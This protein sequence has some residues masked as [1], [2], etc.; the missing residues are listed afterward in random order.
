M[1][2]ARR[3]WQLAEQ[4]IASIF[5]CRRQPGSGSS[6]RDDLTQSDST[7]PRLFIE[8]KLRET[9]AARTLHDETR[10]KAKKEHKTPVVALMDKSRP[11]ALLCIHTDDLDAFVTEYAAANHDRLWPAV[12]RAIHRDRGLEPG[13]IM[14]PVECDV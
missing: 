9:H 10:V 4:R 5:G 1:S 12:I 8:C 11:G 7:H 6:G 14:P 2:T 13:E 3:T